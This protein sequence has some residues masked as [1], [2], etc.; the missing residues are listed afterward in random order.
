MKDIIV[1][2]TNRERKYLEFWQGAGDRTNISRF[3][4]TEDY[5]S[6]MVTSDDYEKGDYLRLS[7]LSLSYRLPSSLVKQMRLTNMTLSFNARNLL[8][9][10]KYKGLDVGS[11]GAFT[12]PVSRE[13]NLKLS[14]GF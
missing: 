12:Y 14:V 10:T 9:F 7:N 3:V 2:G 4:T 11:G 5:W 8:T 6:G 13:F 1:S